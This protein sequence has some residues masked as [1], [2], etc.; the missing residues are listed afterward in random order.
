[1]HEI[2]LTLCMIVKNEEE[3]IA[4]CLESVKD[5]V[6]EM[7]IVDTG[8]S[9]RTVEICEAYDA[10]VL[11]YEWNGSF[12]EARNHGIKQASGDWIIWLDADEELEQIDKKELKGCIDDQNYDALNVRLI[13]YHGDTIDEN[14]TSEIAHTRL[15]KN[16][17]ILFVNKMHER[18][19]LTS[20][21]KDRVGYLGINVYHYGYL[22]SVIEKKE[23]AKRNISMLEAQIDSG[24]NVY[25]AHYY[26][27]LEH[28]NGKQ[29]NEALERTNLSILSFLQNK[30]LPPSMVYK[31]KYS[32]L[33]AMGRFDLALHGIDKAI[34]MYPDYVDLTFLKG[35][36]LYHLESYEAS[37]Q[38]FHEC[39]KMGEDNV[40]HLILKGAGSFR[41]WYYIGL[42]ER[43]SGQKEDAMLSMMKSLCVAPH[44]KDA[45]ENLA[46][47]IDT[48]DQRE[49]DTTIRKLHPEEQQIINRVIGEFDEK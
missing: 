19:D 11:A 36:I 13:N 5:I 25:W 2:Q 38:C 32:I 49:I 37:I 28:Y 42:C 34:R 4:R 21:P 3:S 24:E 30:T 15:F 20:I 7:I 1:M 40:A 44:Y 22:N 41:A 48:C 46:D 17:G 16:S 29:Y 35:I 8:S 43:E 31:L 39:I 14:N 10:K 33:I 27:A 26:L 18:L 6:D 47:M 12:A 9:D 45:M 23:K